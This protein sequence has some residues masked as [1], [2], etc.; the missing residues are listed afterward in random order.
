MQ[1]PPHS[2]LDMLQPDRLLPLLS[3]D[4]RRELVKLLPGENEPSGSTDSA[5]AATADTAAAAAAGSVPAAADGSVSSTSASASK[6]LSAS[7]S[8]HLHG[9]QFPQTPER[10]QSL[11]YSENY[12]SLLS[13]LGLDT[14]AGGF[15]V[16]GLVAAI[17]RQVRLDR[18]KQTATS[19]AVPQQQPPA[20]PQ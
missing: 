3:D 15:G 18:E 9:D 14:S 20:Q 16:E 6:T 12:G 17:E 8:R 1:L 11:L 13:S 7:L 2:L 10:M 19:G 5:T 4:D